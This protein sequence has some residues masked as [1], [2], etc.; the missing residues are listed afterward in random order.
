MKMD[1]EA[2]QARQA[3]T[4][5]EKRLH[6]FLAAVKALKIPELSWRVSKEPAQ[7]NISNLECFGVSWRG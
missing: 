2:G 1:Y 3:T 6:E 4:A 7:N 5:G